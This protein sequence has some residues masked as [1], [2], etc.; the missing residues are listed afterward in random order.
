[1]G[2]LWYK[3]LS[4]LTCLET[5]GAE[6]RAAFLPLADKVKYVSAYYN[7]L[8][9]PSFPAPAKQLDVKLEKTSP[10]IREGQRRKGR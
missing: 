2:V 5:V 8:S 10:T 9:L 7:D 4:Y 6:D 3:L 1:M